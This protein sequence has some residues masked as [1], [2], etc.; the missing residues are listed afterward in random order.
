MPTACCAE[1]AVNQSGSC[2]LEVSLD[3]LVVVVCEPP[4]MAHRDAL[5]S[6]AV[7][8]SS[9]S[10]TCQPGSGQHTRPATPSRTAVA[11]EQPRSIAQGLGCHARAPDQSRQSA[12][13]EPVMHGLQAPGI[14]MHLGDDHPIPPL[15]HHCAL[16]DFTNEGNDIGQRVRPASPRSSAFSNRARRSGLGHGTRIQQN[17]ARGADPHAPHRAP[18]GERNSTASKVGVMF[19]GHRRYGGRDRHGRHGSGRR[20]DRRGGTGW[21]L[22]T[23]STSR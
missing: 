4:F 3:W 1:A 15:S 2:V 16:S 10:P 6:P 5:P 22:P 18:P 8:S 7:S 14:I 19:S 9:K 13:D 11:T 17:G 20:G 23:A 12:T 21:P